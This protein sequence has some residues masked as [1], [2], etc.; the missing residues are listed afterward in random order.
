VLAQEITGLYNKSYPQI[1]RNALVDYLRKKELSQ[2]TRNHDGRYG[3]IYR[4]RK[5]IKRV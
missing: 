4:Y 3:F 5:W 1:L 2:C